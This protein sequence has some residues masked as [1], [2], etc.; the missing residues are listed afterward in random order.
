MSEWIAWDAITDAMTKTRQMLFEPFDLKKWVKLAIILFFISS[1]SL[2]FGSSSSSSNFGNFD[3]SQSDAKLDAFIEEAVSGVSVFM[4]QYLLYIV[5][6][7]LAILLLIALF[8]YIS[9]VMQFVF[10]ESV[11]KNQVTLKAYIRNNLGNGLRL[12]ILN[13]TLGVLF[14]AALI[15]SLLPA[16]SAIMEGNFS[17]LFFGSLLM[18]FFVIVFG[19]IIFS[20]I[21]SFINLAI[22]VMLYEDVG[23]IIGIAASYYR[24]HCGL[25]RRT[26]AAAD[27]HRSLSD[28]HIT[29]IRI[30]QYGGSRRARI[31]LCCLHAGAHI[32][33]NP[34]NRTASRIHEISCTPLPSELVCGYLAILGASARTCEG[35][36]E[37]ES[38][39]LILE[40]K[41]R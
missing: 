38:S 39:K 15:L 34:R 3:G 14:L 7:V 4:H 26:P 12:F 36:L 18:P 24:S 6:A 33:G 19:S 21:G 2:N 30:S 32:S 5:L 9:N 16:F 35:Y 17:V 20:L 28:S 37:L 27:R 10:V 25:D 22:P 29:G 31:A 40:R 41:R 8:S 11:V 13:W 23:I 1:G